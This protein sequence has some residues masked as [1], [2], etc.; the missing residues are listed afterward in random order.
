MITLVETLNINYNGAAIS[1]EFDQANRA[2][3]FIHA[4]G[5]ELFFDGHTTSSTNLEEFTLSAESGV[6]AAA[7]Y[8]TSGSGDAVIKA[9]EAVTT[10]T[11]DTCY[12]GRNYIINIFIQHS[13]FLFINRN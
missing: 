11:A 3:T 4:K 9:Y 2:I 13:L 1:Y 12:S 8:D 10:V 7:S 5:G 6:L